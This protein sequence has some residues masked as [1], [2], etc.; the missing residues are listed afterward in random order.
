[1]RK[2][3][4][5]AVGL[6][7]AMVPATAASAQGR[8]GYYGGYGYGDREVRQEI[9][10]CRRELRRADSRREYRRE[11]RECR[12]EIARAQRRGYRYYDDDYS[13]YRRHPYYGQRRYYRRGW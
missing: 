1:M 7:A 3:I 13:Y 8:Y 2:L 12:R 6:A 9:R 5:A 11:L 10:E 4:L